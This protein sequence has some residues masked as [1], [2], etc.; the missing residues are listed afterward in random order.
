[1]TNNMYDSIVAIDICDSRVTD[2]KYNYQVAH[3]ICNFLVENVIY[4]LIKYAKFLNN[5]LFR[6]IYQTFS[7]M[8]KF[9]KKTHKSISICIYIYI[10][11]YIFIY[12]S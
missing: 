11:I 8:C 1:M 10:Y 12:N 2:K 4:D 3:V 5:F 7:L 6:L 9:K